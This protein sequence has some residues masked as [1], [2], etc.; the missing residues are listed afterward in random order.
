MI[1]LN[2]LQQPPYKTSTSQPYYQ[3]HGC[4]YLPTA[5]TLHKQPPVYHSTRDTTILTCL[6][7]P[8]YN[9]IQLST[10][11]SGTRLY[12][13]GFSNHL[14]ITSTC[15]PYYQRHDCTYLLT[16]IT[17]HI[18][19]TCLPFYQRHSHTYLPTATTF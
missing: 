3:R 10:I 1:V 12:L 13:P 18:T 17:L 15:Q 8:P 19:S 9:S 5:I 14:T 4:I 16:A 2:R 6:Q 11:L 7:N